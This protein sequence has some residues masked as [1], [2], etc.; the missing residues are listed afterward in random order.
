MKTETPPVYNIYFDE[1]QQAVVMQWE[2]YATSAQFREGTELMLNELIQHK[3]SRVL[4]DI[5]HMALI[6][7]DDQRWLLDLFLPR[8]LKFGFRSVAFLKPGSYFN[9][10]AVENVTSKIGAQLNMGFFEN[11]EEA[12]QWLKLH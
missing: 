10:V 2:G 3:A 7:S 5:R 11:S 6:G 1:A 4:A 9:Q 12:W 8:A